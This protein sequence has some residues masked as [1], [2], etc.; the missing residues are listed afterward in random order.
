M[1]LTRSAWLGRF[2]LGAAYLLLVALLI[3]ACAAQQAA[4]GHA[5]EGNVDLP[6]FPSVSPDGSQIVFS[7]RGDLWK[8]SSDGGL[9]IRLTRHAGDDLRSAWSRDGSK[10]AF[11]STRSGYLN[12][13]LMQ[14]DGT[15]VRQLSHVDQSC[16]LS[17]FGIDEAGHEV[18]LFAAAVEGDPDRLM[19]P[20]MIGLEGGDLIRLHDAF[21]SEPAVSPNGRFVAFTRGTSSWHRRHSRNPNTRDVWIYDR[22]TK[23]FTQITDWPGND[24]Q[25]R[26]RNNDELLYLSDRELNCVNIYRV[27]L[28]GFDPASFDRAALKHERLTSFTEADV[29]NFDVSVDGNTAVFVVWDTLY[30]LDLQSPTSEPI[31]LNIRGSTD[32]DDNFQL[33]SVNREVTEA[34]LSPDG[35]VM[36]VI[37]RGELFI[38][39]VDDGSP[40]V[41]VTYTHAREKQPAWSPDGTRLYFVSTKDGIDSICVATVTLTRSDIRKQFEEALKAAEKAKTES[42]EKKP[43]QDESA[44]EEPTQE[45]EETKEKSESDDDA[46]TVQGAEKSDVKEEA[47]KEEPKKE[48]KDKEQPLDPK[49][50]HDA[51]R[52]EIKTLIE[53]PH[54]DSSPSPSPD[55]KWLAFMRAPGNLMLLDLETG[56]ER[57]L[58]KGW[59]AQLHW[60]WSA[61]SRYIAYC[62]ADRSFNYDIWVVP[63]DGSAKPVNVS[64]HPQSDHNP[65]WSADG[66]ILNF[67]SRRVDGQYDLYSVYLDKELEALAG[68]ELNKYYEDAVAAAKK[69]KP[70]E[71]KKPG[72]KSEDAGRSQSTKPLDLDDAYLRLRRIT[73][74]T[75]SETN[76][77]ITPGGD[78]LVYNTLNGVWSCKWDGSDNK[79]IGGNA[80]VQHLTL[81]GDKVVVVE[82]GR[83]AIITIATGTTQYIDISDRIR[84]DLQEQASQKF[85]EAARM[86]GERFYHPTMK[87]LDWLALT[88]RYHEL[89]RRTRTASEFNDVANRFLGELNASHLS[90]NSPSERMPNAQPYGRL[91]T[92]HRRVD[93]GFEVVAVVPET[94]AAK[95]KMALQPGDVITAIELQPIG[96]TDTIESMLKGRVGEETLITIR[97]KIGDE[98]RELHVFMRPIS[99]SDFANLR[100]REWRLT[101]AE[102]VAQWSNGR[103]GYIHIRSMNEASLEE[104]ERD[105]YAAA[106]DKEGLIIDVRNNGG[107]WIADRL[108]ASIMV[109]PHAYTV[110]RG[111]EPVDTSNAYPLD[112]LFIQRYTLPINTLCN[113]ASFSNAEIFAHA[114]K[115]LGRGTL[116]GQQ[117][118]GGVISTGSYTLIDG[119]TVRVPFRGWYLPDGTDMENNGAVPDILIPQT[120]EMEAAGD[121]AQLR[122][123]VED[124]LRRLPETEKTARE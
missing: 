101:T 17:G 97:R 99:F 68:Q 87:G 78:R 118:A 115:T 75:N 4:P 5:I 96:P 59:N 54:N 36:A 27:N 107:G 104:F 41:R 2:P 120:P 51:I 1:V 24:G 30:R 66:K 38:R 18:V 76:N 103:I 80:Q 32:D 123:A 110:P 49:R 70:L 45:G 84:I 43:S 72:A 6:R 119:T 13:H 105:L 74:T 23:T 64:R 90:V 58:H 63:V 62:D 3:S 121:D 48:P 114:F 53:S 81:T 98:P 50:W 95:G 108:L 69:R 37:A 113:E 86:L 9:A 34:A 91:G 46:A 124:L 29:Q 16:I 112:R 89:A 92:I 106:G 79:R 39:N 20:Y 12:V 111:A 102:K 26:W 60:S 71:V 116:V 19:R 42:S 94:P 88:E 67:I 35:K 25:A 44:K 57:V 82:G 15:D 52:F 61:D 28:R 85:L 11:T 8:V 55:G 10:I 47:E 73:R 31:A 109:Q 77:L 56:T 83:A 100:Y 33:L 117:T 21:G 93:D 65:Q 40:T 14:A 22:Q 122:A 7:W